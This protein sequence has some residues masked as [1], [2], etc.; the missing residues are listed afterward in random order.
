MTVYNECINIKEENTM[1][2]NKDDIYVV[3]EPEWSIPMFWEDLTAIIAKLI[4]L[5]RSLF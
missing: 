5:I 4:D 2:E 1:N 3:P